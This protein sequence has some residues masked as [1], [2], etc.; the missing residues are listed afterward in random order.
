MLPNNREKL[1][2]NL[3]AE[4]NGIVPSFTNDSRQSGE[5]CLSEFTKR[6]ALQHWS[7]VAISQMT[8][9]ST[10]LSVKVP[11]RSSA[12]ESARAPTQSLSLSQTTARGHPR[13][14]E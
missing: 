1:Y 9:D 10:F 7:I 2:R 4:Q 5:N 13:A 6:L 12:I 3:L 11:P 14:K 8:R